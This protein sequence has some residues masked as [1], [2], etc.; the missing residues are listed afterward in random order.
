MQPSVSIHRP[1]GHALDRARRKLAMVL[2]GLRDHRNT[3]S[4][5]RQTAM[6][7]TP[8]VTNIATV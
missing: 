3:A 4:N 8:V 6:A 1:S 5:P 7:M 2:R